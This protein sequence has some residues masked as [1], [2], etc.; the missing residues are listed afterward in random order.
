M[1]RLAKGRTCVSCALR[2]ARCHSI[3]DMDLR[4]QGLAGAFLAKDDADGAQ[5]YLQVEAE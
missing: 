3:H 1:E 4:K 2:P 5:E